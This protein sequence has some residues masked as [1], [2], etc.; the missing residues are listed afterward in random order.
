MVNTQKKSNQSFSV[1]SSLTP[2][3]QLQFKIIQALE[4]LFIYGLRRMTLW[5]STTSG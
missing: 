3:Y 4:A 1:S 2:Y 5:T